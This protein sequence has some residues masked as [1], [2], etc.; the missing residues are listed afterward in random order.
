MRAVPNAE[1]ILRPSPGI[2]EAVNRDV[3]LQNEQQIAQLQSR[4]NRKNVKK[5]FRNSA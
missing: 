5:S 3:D 2:E 4:L 1:N